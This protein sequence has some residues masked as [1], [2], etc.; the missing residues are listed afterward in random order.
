MSPINLVKKMKE[1]IDKVFI[2][3][4]KTFLILLCAALITYFIAPLELS[5]MV[6]IPVY[7]VALVLFLLLVSYFIAVFLRRQNISKK[8]KNAGI[9][10][11]FSTRNEFLSHYNVSSILKTVRPHSDIFVVARSGAAWADEFDSIEKAIIEH[12]ITLTIIMSDPELQSHLMPIKDDW[13]S[14]D[15]QGS[16]KKLKKIRVGKEHFS[17]IKI[18]LL[19]TYVLFSFVCFLNRD[20][21]EIGILELGADLPLNKRFSII[22]KDGQLLGNLKDTYKKLL[23]GRQ[24]V[25]YSISQET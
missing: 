10:D 14:L 8:I 13:A 17:S 16:I 24:P 3:F 22:C 5:K 19:P 15:L 21:E 11:L 1:L 23:I 7:S 18:Y 12:D 6:F 20:N 4:I 9:V 25:D 2:D